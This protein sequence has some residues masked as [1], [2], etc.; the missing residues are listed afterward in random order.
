MEKN[1]LGV[2]SYLYLDCGKISSDQQSKNTDTRKKKMNL[3]EVYLHKEQPYTQWLTRLFNKA[4]F[5]SHKVL[6]K[7]KMLRK[8]ILSCSV[9]PWQIQNKVKYN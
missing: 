2:Y 7:K 1:K 5:D 9:L 6:R 3:K 8:I 4:M